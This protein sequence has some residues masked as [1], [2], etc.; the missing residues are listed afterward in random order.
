[1]NKEVKHTPTPWPTDMVEKI[2]MAGLS[3]LIAD[4]DLGASAVAAI[5]DGIAKEDA[6]HIVKCVNMHDELVEALKALHI[7]ALQSNVN[8][9]AN[10]WGEEALSMSLATLKKAGAL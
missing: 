3:K 1:M 7:Q 9:P 8:S 2:W 6:A 10:E 4:G 5:F